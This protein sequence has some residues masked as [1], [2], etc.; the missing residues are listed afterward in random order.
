[1]ERSDSVFMRAF[2]GNKKS[3]SHDYFADSAHRFPHRII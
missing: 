3:I 2:A 1:M